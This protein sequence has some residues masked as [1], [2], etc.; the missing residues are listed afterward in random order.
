MLC[1]YPMAVTLLVHMN[2]V[3]TK[4]QVFFDLLEFPA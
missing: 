1:P 4:T 3:V 2:M